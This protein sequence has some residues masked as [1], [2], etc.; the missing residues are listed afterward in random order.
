MRSL[1]WLSA[2]GTLAIL[3]STSCGSGHSGAGTGTVKLKLT[4]APASIDAVNLVVD[5]VSVH[6]VGDDDSGWEVIRTDTFTVDLLTLRNGVFAD[7]A[8][9]IVPAGHYNQVRLKLT[10]GS[11]ITVDG[12]T[13]PLTVPS[14]MSSGYK[15][16]GD[17]EVP[18]GGTVTL[19]LDFDAEQ[20]VHQTGN[21]RW[22]LRPT[23]KVMVENQAGSI[24]GSV[25]PASQETQVF[26]LSGPDTVSR[27]TSGGNGG[28]VLGLL[29]AGTYDVAF[30][31]GAGYR[32]TTRAG[33][34]VSAGQTT[35]IGAT[36]LTPE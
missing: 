19:L 7:F 35:D 18:E 10:D 12:D 29:S 23:C 32:D 25:D 33:I 11:T 6:R 5:Q 27:A 3:F 8:E 36:V 21:G 4:D 26:A 14:G 34:S 28:F 2:L 22:M 9:G 24:S 15:I 13:Q 20:S 30:D 1:T 17:F 16:H 31:P